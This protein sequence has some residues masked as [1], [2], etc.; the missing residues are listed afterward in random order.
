M[1]NWSWSYIAEAAEVERLRR[2]A[3]EE[4]SSWPHDAEASGERKSAKAPVEERRRSGDEVRRREESS[5]EAPPMATAREKEGFAPP[6]SRPRLH[7]R[8]A[9]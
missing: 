2:G 5:L 8:W 7:R 6:A 3:G 9:V 4:S 1:P